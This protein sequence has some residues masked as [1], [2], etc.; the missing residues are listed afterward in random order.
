MK[1]EQRVTELHPVSSAYTP[2][3]KFEMDAVKIDLI[4]AR[5][6]NSKWLTEQRAK[7]P[8]AG[9]IADG[10]ERAEM[11]V[12]D[13]VLVGLDETSVRSV[14]GVRVAQFL[15]DAVGGHPALVDN[16]QL[17]LRAVKEWARVHGLYSNVL[18]FLGGV[19]WAILVVWV[20]KRN[21]D[22]PASKLLQLFFR[23]FANWSWPNQVVLSS[24]QKH[25]PE[26]VRPLPVWDPT[27]NY[28]DK[29]AL[30]PI[31]TPCY[32]PMNS[33]YNVGGPQLRRLRDEL[34]R[35]SALG[36]DV[37]AGR[38]DW[39]ALFAGNDFFRQHANYLQVDI[40]ASNAEEFRS[41]FGL[42]ES[43]MRILI[44][45]LESPFLQAHPFAKFFPNRRGE[46]HVSSFFVAL[47]FSHQAKRVDLGPLVADYLRIVNDWEG[48]LTGMDLEIRLVLKK[49]LPSFVFEDEEVKCRGDR[50]DACDEPSATNNPQRGKH[51]DEE[52]AET[53]LPR[54][55]LVDES[56]S[57]LDDVGSHKRKKLH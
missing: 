38:R 22:A 39:D 56:A 24:D 4:F 31:I 15:L 33:A 51:A 44:A 3:I 13:S 35:A 42:C 21:P 14:N 40:I 26:G 52:E 2:V 37:L 20:S 48:R 8:A 49:N 57:L 9:A 10:G 28:R 12:D 50:T 25:P 29:K 43:K 11:R 16:F 18:G 7:M 41:W 55:Q 54:K 5:V 30:M 34:R 1:G 53:P 19:N 17:A 6:N 32:P 45:S 47:R 23:T 27:E 46:A 36:E